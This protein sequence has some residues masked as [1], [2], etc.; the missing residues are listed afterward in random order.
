MINTSSPLFVEL[1]LCTIY[2]LLAAAVVLTA[3]SLVRGVRQQGRGGTLSNGIPA[4]R[5]AW[6][7]AALLLVV[8]LLTY[9]FGSTEP[10][11]INGKT[12]ADPFWL[13]TSDMLINSSAV[14]IVIAAIGVLL[15]SSGVG[16]RLRF[17]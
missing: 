15:G 2:L 1:L 14:L 9:A 13:R 3:W 11:Q 16:R 10:L 4:G 12:F 5:I 8:L 6:W 7:T 17:K